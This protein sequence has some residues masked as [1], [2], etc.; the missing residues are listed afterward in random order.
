[1]KTAL[2]FKVGNVLVENDKNPDPF[3]PPFNSDFCES[4]KKTTSFDDDSN[5]F[6]NPDESGKI[7]E[8]WSKKPNFKDKEE[9]FSYLSYL[10]CTKVSKKNQIQ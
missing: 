7:Y 6:Y 9:K 4:N 2:Y 8:F 3:N 5:R 1:M 10:S